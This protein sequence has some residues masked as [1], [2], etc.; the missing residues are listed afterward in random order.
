M[1]TSHAVLE[2]LQGSAG[3][4]EKAFVQGK[5]RAWLSRFRSR[6]SFLQWASLRFQKVGFHPLAPGWISLWEGNVMFPIG[7]GIPAGPLASGHSSDTL[8]R[9]QLWSVWHF[10]GK[11]WWYVQRGIGRQ[12]S[13]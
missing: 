6:S 7:S 10:S 9:K 4:E 3:M 8:F 2:L 12:T 13:P 11:G 5:E 1:R